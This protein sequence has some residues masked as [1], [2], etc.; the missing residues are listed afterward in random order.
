MLLRNSPNSMVHATIFFFFWVACFVAHAAPPTRSATNVVRPQVPR[1]QASGVNPKNNLIRRRPASVSQDGET[2]EE[3][4]NAW[5]PEKQRYSIGYEGAALSAVS[6]IGKNAMNFGCW[7]NDSWAI[8]AYFGYTKDADT[9]SDTTASIGDAVAN[10]STVTVTHAG[11]KNAN[12]FTLGAGV[13]YRVFQNSWFQ[14]NVG[15]LLTYTPGVA[16]SYTTGSITTTTPNLNSPGNQTIS[17]TGLGT[18]S[19]NTNATTSVGPKLGTEFYPRWFPHLALGF[20]TGILTTFGSESTVTT[21]TRTRTYTTLGGTAQ[22]PSADTTTNSVASLK[23]GTRGV[24][25]GVG[26]AQFQLIGT[27]TIRY[28]W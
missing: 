8:D 25:F 19:S 17:E 12:I 15:G 11:I 23:P 3:T 16:A 18:I 7:L 5:S 21:S 28:I 27:F 24:T 9:Y 13:R 26:G 2:Q 14:F 10:S 4:F 1:E 22:P 20:S 6:V